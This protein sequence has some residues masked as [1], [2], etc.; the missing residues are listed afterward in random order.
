MKKIKPFTE[1]CICRW[2][3]NDEFGFIPNAECP[4]H[5]KETI[6][7]FM[8]GEEIEVLK[9]KNGWGKPYGYEKAKEGLKKLKKFPKTWGRT[10]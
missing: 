6:K 5:G 2:S 8:E 1:T 9:N 4:V 3:K 10:Y 7:K